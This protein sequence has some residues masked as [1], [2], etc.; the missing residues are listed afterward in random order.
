MLADYTLP[1]FDG[2]AAL[3]IVLAERPDIPFIFVSGSLGEERAIEALKSGATDYVL[4]DRLQRLPTVV[5]RALTEA[6]ER[7]ERRKAQVALEEQRVL[8]EDVDGQPSGDDLRR[9]HEQPPHDGQ[10]RAAR[11][12]AQE[13]RRG[14]GPTIVRAMDRGERRRHR[15]AGRHDD[16]HR[17]HADRS[18][19]SLDTC[20]R[21]GALVHVHSRA[22]CAITARRSGPRLHGSGSHGSQSARTGN[23]RDL[24]PRAASPRQRSARRP[25]PGAHRP[26]AAA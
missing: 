25:R 26:V 3:K 8:L 15:G 23:P 7:R 14:A 10:S 11:H 13:T 9:R 12:V 21:L 1:G 20:G 16:A 4:K 18:G 22:A 17:T 2:L 6:S 5:Q 24:E 19:A